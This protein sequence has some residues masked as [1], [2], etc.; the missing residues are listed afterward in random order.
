MI[1]HLKKWMYVNDIDNEKLIFIAQKIELENLKPVIFTTKAEILYYFW[2][3]V[4]D[5]ISIEDF[6]M[7]NDTFFKKKSYKYKISNWVDA[8]EYVKNAY[9]KW[10]IYILDDLFETKIEKEN[11]Y[12]I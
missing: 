4:N 3:L 5:R 9:K 12:F 2:Q 11:V 1:E 10:N 6:Y 8:I 7:F